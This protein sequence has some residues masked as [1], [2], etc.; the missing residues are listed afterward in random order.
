MLEPVHKSEETMASLC[1]FPLSY[2]QEKGKCRSDK[3]HTWR[4]VHTLRL[5]VCTYAD[6]CRQ[7]CVCKHTHAFPIK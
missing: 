6:T 3:V 1:P 5:Q 4:Q 7:A 2:I